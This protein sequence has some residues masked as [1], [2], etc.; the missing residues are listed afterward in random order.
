M[1]LVAC[2]G[3]IDIRVISPAANEEYGGFPIDVTLEMN[4][5]EGLEADRLRVDPGAYTACYGLR[6]GVQQLR[7]V[8]DDAAVLLQVSSEQRAVSSTK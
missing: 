2:R 4:V 6:E 8:P 7:A 1:Q 5:T 3:G